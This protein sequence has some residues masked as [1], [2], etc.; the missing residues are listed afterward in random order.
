[1]AKRVHGISL[2]QKDE[3]L[4]V[5]DEL[6]VELPEDKVRDLEFRFDEFGKRAVGE[7]V[8]RECG[9]RTVT[10]TRAFISPVMPVEKFEQGHLHARIAL[11]HVP[12]R[13]GIEIP[14]SF[15]EG[16]EGRVY[17]KQ[18]SFL[19]FSLVSTASP[20]LA[21]QPA[22]TR[23]PQPGGAGE[24]AAELRHRAVEGDPS[25]DRGFAGLVRLALFR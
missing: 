7:E 22:L 20:A 9:G 21:V 10:P 1:M 24:L 2:F 13:G 15:H 6:L 3:I 4:I 23:V 14:F 16:I 12:D 11:E 5:A 19:F 8:G 18:Q 25:H 17:G